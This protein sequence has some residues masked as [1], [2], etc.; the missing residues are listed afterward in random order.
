[1]SEIRSFDRMVKWDKVTP[2][3]SPGTSS[4]KTPY[5]CG[6]PARVV[7]W[8]DG[9]PPPGDVPQAGQQVA[10]QGLNSL[11]GRVGYAPDSF[12]I[13]S[14]I[15]YQRKDGHWRIRVLRDRDDVA[16]YPVLADLRPRPVEPPKPERTYTRKEVEQA[17]R[18]GFNSC[19]PSQDII[20]ALE[21]GS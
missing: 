14:G 2:S 10:I 20:Q 15:P 7:K 16:S 12:T 17:I 9:A 6:T 21:K 1:M 4:I 18:V 13:S 3:S 8:P 5:P 11:Y 19:I